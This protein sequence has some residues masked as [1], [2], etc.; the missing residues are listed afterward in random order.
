MLSLL[1]IQSYSTEAAFIFIMIPY[2]QGKVEI[3]IVTHIFKD[4]HLKWQKNFKNM[5]LK[6]IS[7]RYLENPLMMPFGNVR[8][9]AG[10][11][12]S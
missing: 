7:F 1:T 10:I 8:R 6:E 9:S 3:W 11:H 2:L 12:G 4:F 5:V